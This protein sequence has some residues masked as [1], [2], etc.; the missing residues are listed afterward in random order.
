MP[1]FL[2][3]PWSIAH[4]FYWHWFNRPHH[5]LARILIGVFGLV[6]LG[7]VLALGLLALIAFA[8][9]VPLAAIARAMTRASA[10]RHP[11]VIEGEFVVLPNRAA[12]VKH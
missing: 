11:N 1:R 12:S 2:I 9:I 10:A 7:G 4:M 5:P 6:L 8:L 3:L